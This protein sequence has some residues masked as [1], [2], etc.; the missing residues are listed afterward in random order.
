MVRSRSETNLN[1]IFIDLCTSPQ[2]RRKYEHERNDQRQHHP[3]L[4][5][6]KTIKS[7]SC[8]NIQELQPDSIASS[9]PSSFEN[10][11]DEQN[12]VLHRTNIEPTPIVQQ[13]EIVKPREST[14]TLLVPMQSTGFSIQ[15]TTHP[16]SPL[17]ETLAISN[18]TFASLPVEETLPAN[19]VFD[20][21]S[22]TDSLNWS[23][24]DRE[25]SKFQPTYQ[26]S[27]S[28]EIVS[29]PYNGNI[30]SK[31]N[32]YANNTHNFVPIISRQTTDNSA[33]DTL[34]ATSTLISYNDDK[35]RNKPRKSQSFMSSF[36]RTIFHRRKKHKNDEQNDHDGD[37][38]LNSTM[39]SDVIPHSLSAEP[40][41]SLS[42]TS[43]PKFHRGHSITRSFRN[44]FRSKGNKKT[45]DTS[46]VTIDHHDS[47]STSTPTPKKRSFFHPFKS[48]KKRQTNGSANSLTSDDCTRLASARDTP[49]RANVGRPVTMTK[50]LVR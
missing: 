5:T 10:V 50:T 42:P 14:T 9:S 2:A 18:H 1:R 21:A 35:K 31:D 46:N 3:P 45:L 30:P 16:S 20:V 25:A 15:T 47:I 8:S 6:L 13:Q 27:P 32:N 12:D 23:N 44:I 11:Q 39:H 22:I 49:V 17:F 19:N 7:N 26:R 24:T 38:S 37:S 33:I 41:V 40:C 29:L 28:D 34:S 36:R 43:P 4:P 48:G